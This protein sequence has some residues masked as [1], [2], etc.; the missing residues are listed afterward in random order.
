MAIKQPFPQ[1]LWERY[2]LTN[3]AIV[4]PEHFEFASTGFY[5]K[6]RSYIEFQQKMPTMY[7]LLTINCT[8]IVHGDDEQSQKVNKHMT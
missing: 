3:H 4:L 6:L 1:S 5:C 8:S 2:T 7:D